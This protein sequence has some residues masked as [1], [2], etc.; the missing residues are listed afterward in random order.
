[1]M[2]GDVAGVEGVDIHLIFL[3]EFV[4]LASLHVGFEAEDIT[5]GLC[6]LKAHCVRR[7][8]DFL[9]LNHVNRALRCGEQS[10]EALLAMW[11]V[12]YHRFGGTARSIYGD[13]L[14]ARGSK[15]ASPIALRRMDPIHWLGD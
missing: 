6:G 8:A 15:T 2:K 10:S 3:I 12:S 13:H 11:G 5:Q 1:M 9:S 7:Q 14:S 4:V